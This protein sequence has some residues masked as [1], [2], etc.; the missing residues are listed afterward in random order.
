MNFSLS[1]KRL[2]DLTISFLG[3]IL[4]GPFLLL[5]ALRIKKDSPGPVF[6]R[7]PRLGLGGRTFHILKFRTMTED[8][9]SY[10]GP[11][12]TAAG[13]P[14]I[15]PLGKWLRDTKLNELPQLWNVF[16]G[17]MS[18]VGP[19]PEDPQIAS[20][21]W[22]PEQR[23]EILSLRPGITSPASVLFRHEEDLLKGNGD[24]SKLMQTYL[25]DVMPSKLRLDQLYVR[26]RSFLLDLDVL[27]WTAVILLPLIGKYN[28]P[29]ESFFLGPLNR[30]L[31]RYVSWF[32]I[33]AAVT[34]FAMT[35]TG[36]SWRLFGPLDVGILNSFLLVLFYSF[37]FS[38]LSALAG[39][40]R[41]QW[42]RAPASEVLALLPPLVFSTFM[43][44]GINYLLPS[45]VLPY[46][47]ILIA[48]IL[49]GMGYVIV[50]YRTRV[51]SGI[52][53]RWINLRR[54]ASLFRERVLI[55]GGG[56]SGQFLAWLLQNGKAANAFQIVGIVDDDLYK[57]KT[58]IQ[59]V[60]VIGR[61]HQI[62]E[63]VQKHDIGIIAFAIHNIAP[64]E[65][66]RLLK[67]ANS[68]SAR[69]IVLPNLIG[70]I[71]S[72]ARPTQRLQN[73]SGRNG[74]DGKNGNGSN[75]QHPIEAHPPLDQEPASLQGEISQSMGLTTLPSLTESSGV[76]TS[77]HSTPCSFCLTQCS[78][79]QIERWLASLQHTAQTGDNTA[80]LKEIA[81]LRSQLL[82]ISNPLR[83]FSAPE[84][85]AET[86]IQGD[87]DT[88]NLT[89]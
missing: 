22:T 16:Q 23:R 47:L 69:L 65:R 63:L 57:L 67:L 18:L 19:R 42:S 89:S 83:D 64:L 9:A 56:E 50:R 31:R 17:D 70:A 68:T 41:V 71:N 61:T 62:N 40:N 1:L 72:L 34:F 82:Q 12:I 45:E 53:T 36:V 2:L 5:I 73:G 78:P 58:R 86:A 75:G 8:A 33:D 39:V 84:P 26:H 80:L 11:K 25:G 43:V 4:L 77:E 54:E 32:M 15:T 10:A 52:A 27:F 35:I 79:V 13:D 38:T 29:E 66:S 76:Q 55:I 74:K 85:E 59:G 24:V 60:D 81:D 51:I 6:Y 28:P 46:P 87:I 21:D 20:T 49:A 7:G 3:L 37:V 44:L 88:Y 48:S 14:R 30:T